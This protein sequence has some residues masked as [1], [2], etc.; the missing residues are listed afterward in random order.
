MEKPFDVKDL[1][2][3][4]EAMGI[5]LAKDSAE[6]MAAGLVNAVFDWTNESISASPTKV[7]DLALAVL[8][9]LRAYILSK[10]EA[11]SE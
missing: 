2:K 6:K 8:P 9:P 4:L 1:I 7:D 5:P 11:I 10:I 3:K